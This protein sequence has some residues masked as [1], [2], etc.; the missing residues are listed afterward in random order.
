MNVLMKF[1]ATTV[2]TTQHA[3][4]MRVHLIALVILGTQAMAL[5]VKVSSAYSDNA[6]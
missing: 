1:E 6:K 2:I 3:K 4:I 5:I